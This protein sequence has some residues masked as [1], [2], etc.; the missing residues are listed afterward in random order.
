MNVISK[1]NFVFFEDKLIFFDFN[2]KLQI[3]IG[4]YQI[5]IVADGLM[6][7]N[8]PERVIPVRRIIIGRM[9][10]IETI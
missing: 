9:D 10:F 4:V 8:T 1:T 5:N 6:N 7:K 2:I 3:H